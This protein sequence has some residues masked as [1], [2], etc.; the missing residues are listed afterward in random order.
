MSRAAPAL[1]AALAAG[2]LLGACFIESATPST[3]RFSC[4][5]DSDCEAGERCASGLCQLPCGGEGEEACPEEAPVCLN[6]YC[7]SICPSDQE[8][9][10]A[11]QECVALSSEPD[12]SGVCT[13]LC[14]EQDNPCPEEDV[15]FEGLC[16]TV[17][18]SDEDCGSG[19]ICL[20]GVFVCVPSD[21][22][23]G[24]P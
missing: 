22:G 11:P 5:S 2:V 13:V 9:C 19:E 3:F 1:L 21:S 6:G 14:D 16:A 18:M 24:P 15:C 7:S 20:E 12:S 8:V 17:C 23:G 4:E 10:P